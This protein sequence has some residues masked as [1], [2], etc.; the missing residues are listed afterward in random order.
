VPIPSDASLPSGSHVAFDVQLSRPAYVYL[1]QKSASGA[2]H[3]LFPDARVPVSNP[4]AAS[5]PLQIPTGGTSFKLDDKDLGTERVY[6]VASLKPVT[7]LAAA[8][9]HAS[10]GA[11]V[12]A[13]IQQV[14]TI[15]GS[16]KSRGLSL[17]EGAAAPAAGC[18]RPR[19]LSLDTTGDSKASMVA[20][21]EAADDTIAT[22]FQFRHT[23]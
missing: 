8:A 1:F 11:P 22:V 17:D 10:Q 16:C 19:G 4:I 6:I 13:A 12:G 14:T 5:T 20:T 3:V 9:D 18:A 7:A 21:T 2:V 15:D 23:H